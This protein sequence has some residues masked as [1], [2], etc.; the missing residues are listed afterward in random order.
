MK[1][2][3][4][5]IVLALSL[6]GCA[7][8]GNIGTGIS[9]VTA[10]VSNPV[11][12]TREAEIEQ[13]IDAAIAVLNGYKKACQQ[14]TADKNCRANISAIQVYTRQIGPLIAQLRNFVDT[15]DQINAIVVYNQ[16]VTLYTNLKTSA[17]N[18]GYNVGNLP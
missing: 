10:S 15:N 16:V 4:L 18:V 2:L 7:Q 12:P 3:S 13:A 5:A 1:K 9:L 11:T 6:A 8:L 17:A 14:G